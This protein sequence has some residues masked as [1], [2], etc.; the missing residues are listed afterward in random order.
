[1]EMHGE[2]WRE[3]LYAYA[4]ALEARRRAEDW[5][6]LEPILIRLGDYR[7][8]KERLARARVRME[9]LCALAV[10][11]A[12]ER[13]TRLALESAVAALRALSA[14]DEAA[15]ALPEAEEKLR[16]IAAR[17]EAEQREALRRRY[18]RDK[19]FFVLRWSAVAALVV[20]LL[21]YIFVFFPGRLNR[22]EELIAMGRGEEALA[23]C[24]RSEEIWET[25]RGG[26][27]LRLAREA[28]AGQM[29]G[30]GRFADAAGLYSLLDMQQELDETYMQWS[31]ELAAQGDTK[32]AIRVLLRAGESEG[33]AHRLSQLYMTRADEAA[34]EAI[35]RGREDTAFARELGDALPEL[36]AQLRY[37]HALY[38][39]GFDL[40]AVY[41]DGV[42]IRDAKL[43]QLQIDAEDAQQAELPL[44]RAL[45]FS[46]I[47]S[48]SEYT[49]IPWLTYTIRSGN[50][51]DRTKDSLYTVRLLPGHMFREGADPVRSFAQ[52]DTVLLMDGVYIEAGTVSV[53]GRIEAPI[54]V[55]HPV[56]TSYPYFEAVAS[57][58]AYDLRNPGRM[59]VFAMETD[60]PLCADEEWMAVNGKDDE[61]LSPLSARMGTLNMDAMRKAL[62]ELLFCAPASGGAAPMDDSQER[63]QGGGGNL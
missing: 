7:D 55:K 22:A 10:L 35:A 19:M 32:E 51:H 24:L 14:M 5:A 1:M 41:P 25:E 44:D 4:C 11:D 61:A 6:K 21:A 23:L 43:A 29:R 63:G 8:C 20:S 28:A 52:A 27:L 12:K 62:D 48:G 50:I 58:A 42:I 16:R 9:N 45:V 37:C 47:E 18:Q 3:P 53:W 38:E 36:D 60:M 2:D 54:G 40:T 57:V 59:Q 15:R 17:E 39:A 49:G 56:W 31:G 26:R 30:E 34:Q 13:E 33:R 46:R